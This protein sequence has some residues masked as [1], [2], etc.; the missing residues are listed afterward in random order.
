LDAPTEISE[1]SDDD[2]EEILVEQ[3]VLQVE[4]DD[5]AADEAFDSMLARSLAL[6]LRPR[7]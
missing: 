1:V 4:S 3:E 7:H 2:V 6:G 5:E